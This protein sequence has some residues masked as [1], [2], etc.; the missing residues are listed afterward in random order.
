MPL[1]PAV[2]NC[3]DVRPA[4]NNTYTCL[5]QKVRAIDGEGVAWLIW[6]RM[7]RRRASPAAPPTHPLHTAVPTFI[8]K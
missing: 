7:P 3:T 5:E 6:A 4:G 2:Q 1:H 8:N